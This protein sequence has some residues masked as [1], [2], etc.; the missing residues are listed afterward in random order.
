MFLFVIDKGKFALGQIVATQGAERA[1]EESG[2]EAETFVQRHAQG[3][4]GELGEHDRKE[5]E[6]ALRHNT[7][8]FSCYK[9]ARG[10]TLY[11]ITEWDR[12]V[13]TI[14]LADEY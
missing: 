14:L 10:E 4:W 7:R 9:T 2:E 3:D 5:N 1:L 13:T 11:V 8:L 12:S 6:R